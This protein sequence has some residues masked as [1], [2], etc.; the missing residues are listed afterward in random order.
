M[1]LNVAKRLSPSGSPLYVIQ[2]EMNLYKVITSLLLMILPIA[3]LFRDWK[4]HDKRTKKHH[5]ITRCIVVLW[6]GGSMVATV[7]VLLDSAQINELIEGKN[8]LIS[9]NEVLT[10]KLN[11]YQRDLNDK[12]HKIKELERAALPRIINAEQ[13]STLLKSLTFK[14]DYQVGV[15]CK[16][17]DTESLQ[18]AEQISNIFNSANWQVTAINRTFFDDIKS[19]LGIAITDGKQTETAIKIANIFNA[20]GINCVREKIRENSVTDVKENTI[21]VIVG[22]KLRK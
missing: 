4:Y 5:N 8:T 3:V 22:S 13:E 20:V 12:E 2:D 6:I 9:Q 10:K 15:I 17:F 18:Y 21:Y 1:M 19:D 16:A 7:F 14:S 11:I